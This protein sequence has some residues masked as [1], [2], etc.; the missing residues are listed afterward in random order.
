MQFVQT[1]TD[2]ASKRHNVEYLNNAGILNLLFPLLWDVTPSIQQL[3]IIAL[4][5]L[6]NHDVKIA[7]SIL[8][9]DILS[10]L[11]KQINKKTVKYIIFI[12][13]SIILM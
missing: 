4:G 13:N 9:R 10:Q 11:L 1:I 6:A 3:T 8:Q 2:L 12:K 5:R 7:D